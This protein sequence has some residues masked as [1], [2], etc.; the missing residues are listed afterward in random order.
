MLSYLS[1]KDKYMKREDFLNKIVDKKM[2]SDEDFWDAFLDA[3]EFS[4]KDTIKKLFD[5]ILSEFEEEGMLPPK[6]LYT[7]KDMTKVTVTKHT[8]EK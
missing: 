2:Q 4:D 3:A 6:W 7:S 8:W 5:L 1:V